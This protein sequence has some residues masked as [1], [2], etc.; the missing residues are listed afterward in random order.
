MALGKL[1]DQGAVGRVHQKGSYDNTAQKLLLVDQ[2]KGNVIEVCVTGE[3]IG[4]AD[5]LGILTRFQMNGE[6]VFFWKDAFFQQFA[7]A[8]AVAIGQYL[9]TLIVDQRNLQPGKFVEIIQYF[10][11]TFLGYFCE[12][13]RSHSK[14]LLNDKKTYE[15]TIH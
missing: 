7:V 12:K 10:L 3:N 5:L 4:L 1:G 6:A 8:G 15:K 2:G 13:T 14:N 11:D 9:L